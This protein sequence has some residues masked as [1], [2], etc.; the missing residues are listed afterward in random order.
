LQWSTYYN[1]DD[2][3]KVEFNPPTPLVRDPAN[4]GV[5]VA[6]LLAYWGQLRTEF[7]H[8]LRTLNLS[9]LTST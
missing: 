9:L 4:P 2:Y 3:D 8:W 5:N 7:T 1:V 6:A